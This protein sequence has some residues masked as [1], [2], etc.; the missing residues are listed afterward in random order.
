MIELENKRQLLLKNRILENMPGSDECDKEIEQMELI[1]PYGGKL[2]DLL[3]RGDERQELIARSIEMPSLQLTMRGVCDIELL[4]TGGFSPL[5]SFMGCL[6]YNRVLDE[7]RFADGTMYPIPVILPVNPEWRTVVGKD[8]VLRGMQNET[9]GLLSVEDF[10][11][12]DAQREML[13]LCGS[14]DARHPLIAEMES[15]G[16]FALTGRLRI[17]NL[18]IYYD[19]IK[20]RRTPADVRTALAALGHSN[21]VA[22]QTR[23][24]MHRAHEELTKRAAQS[25]DGTLL[26]HPVVGTTKPGDVDH[27]TRVRACRILIEKYYD[28]R[29]TLLS[30]LPLAMRMAGPREAVWHAIIRRNHGANHFIVGRDHAGPGND[31]N[32]KP[33]YEPYA[34]QELMARVQAE[35]GVK[36]IPFTE[37]VYIPDDDRYEEHDRVPSGKRTLSLSGSQVRNEYLAKGAPLP[38]WFTRPE[39]A[40][41]LSAVSPPLRQR[42]FCIWF[43]G[44][45]GAGKSTI[46]EILLTRL[47]EFG[48]QVT[49][50][51]G[52]V[53]RTH[54]SRGLGFSKEDRDTNIKRIGWVAGEIVK[55]NGVVVCA[56]VSPYRGA[57]NEARNLVGHEQFILVYVS[58]PLDVCEARDV[59]GSYAK[60]R[61]GELRGF[62]G[63]DDPYEP[64]QN[65]DLCIDTTA[66]PPDGCAQ[67]IVDHLVSR[68][69]LE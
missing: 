48:R 19:F 25:I 18:P 41:L 10:F 65:P 61:R 57:R 43:T 35:I 24:P 22:F 6:D 69:F 7:M 3:V 9:L 1:P 11:P 13:A 32:G 60:A 21:V 33:F 50:L 40:E 59:K 54:L 34:A 62:T 36:M 5:R 42:G 55:H 46:A 52:D 31:S 44:L 15:W 68:G 28:H 4:A 30:L 26:V 37:L 63:V 8:L 29:R 67:M 53:V 66:T 49:L 39:V 17:V 16:P 14:T 51:D 58:T 23:N 45:P 2:V 56:A 64:P 47:Q 12:R 38:E 27:Y 20:L